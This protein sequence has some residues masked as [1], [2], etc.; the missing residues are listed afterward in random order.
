MTIVGRFIQGHSKVAAVAAVAAGLLASAS[1]AFATITALDPD[2][3]GGTGSVHANNDIGGWTF[4]IT[5]TLSITALGMWAGTDDAV[6]QAH[7]LGIYRLSDSALMVG[8]TISGSGDSSNADNYIF[9]NLTSAYLLAP[10]TYFVG[11]S[12]AAGSPDRFLVLGDSGTFVDGAAGIGTG[13]TFLDSRVY[14]AGVVG[15]PEFHDGFKTFYGANFQYNV[16]SDVPE[17]ATLGILGLALAGLG[18]ARRRR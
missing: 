8:A 14:Y 18:V 12:Y 5:G 15:G 9:E 3:L 17:P 6:A 2:G 4:S 11:A 7:Q 13:L 16:V 1:P 10:G